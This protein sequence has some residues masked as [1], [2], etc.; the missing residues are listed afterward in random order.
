MKETKNCIVC[1]K[2]AKSHTG[3]VIDKK[4]NAITAGWCGKHNSDNIKCPHLLN[5]RGCYGALRMCWN[6]RGSADLL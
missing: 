6:Q 5:R 2:K 3:H 1:L 4:G